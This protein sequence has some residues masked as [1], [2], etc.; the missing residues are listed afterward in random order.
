M[1]HSL[2]VQTLAEGVET[3]G[4]L[5]FLRE[6]GCDEVQGYYFSQPVTGDAMADLLRNGSLPQT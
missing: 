3:P 6:R 4:Q 2:G 1:A 5:E